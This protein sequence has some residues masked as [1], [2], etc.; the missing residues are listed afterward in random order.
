MNTNIDKF[1]ELGY[2]VVENVFSKEEISMFNEEVKTFVKENPTMPNASG[3][4]IPDFISHQNY[5]EKTKLM[6][7]NEKLHTVLNNVFTGNDYRFCSHNDIG[8]NR[9]VGW[10]KDKLNGQYAKYELVDIWDEKDGEKHE[11]VKVLTYLED[12]SNNNDGLKLVQGSHTTKEI[13]SSGW[14]QLNPKVGD[15]IIFDQR[16]THRGM[17]RQVPG[18][19]V[20]VSFGFGKNNVFT[21]NFEK[22]TQMRQKHQ[23]NSIQFKSKK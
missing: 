23:N 9:I 11:I 2:L 15:V 13:N 6:K 21:N 20:L 7:D 1:N 19:R 16:I 4:S 17:E 18:S 10:H 3:I 12:H 8:I 14:I 22:G 5:F